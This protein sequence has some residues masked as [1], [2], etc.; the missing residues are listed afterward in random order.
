MK[1]M[2]YIEIKDT[3][4][5]S[6]GIYPLGEMTEKQAIK[7]VIK[8]AK[9]LWRQ[10]KERFYTLSYNIAT[11]EDALDMVYSVDLWRGDINVYDYRTEEFIKDTWKERYEKKKSQ[12]EAELEALEAKLM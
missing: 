12:Y 6:G 3:N 11:D 5:I 2:F 9:E 10:D 1:K 7:E 8:R 4:A